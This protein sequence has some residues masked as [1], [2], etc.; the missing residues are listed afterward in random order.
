MTA[1]NRARRYPRLGL[2]KGMLVAW[3]C[4]GA[5]TVSRIS[6]IGR[7]GIFIATGTPARLGEIVRIA[8]DAP[9]G[10]VRALGLV[11]DSKPGCGMGIE[12]TAMSPEGRA[13]L[14]VLLHRLL[15]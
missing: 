1:N 4:S 12:F 8:F 11:R 9:P 14:D 13:S 10:V 15:Q 6:T 2:P 7:G 3:Q 5:R